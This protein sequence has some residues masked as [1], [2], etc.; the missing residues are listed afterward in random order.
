MLALH[1][2]YRT[3]YLDIIQVDPDAP[4]CLLMSCVH[5]KQMAP[6]LEELIET[7]MTENVKNSISL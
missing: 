5:L 4:T 3:L 1:Y 6:P 7:C 2:V